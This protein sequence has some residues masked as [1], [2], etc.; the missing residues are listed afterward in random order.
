MFIAEKMCN[1]KYSRMFIVW[2]EIMSFNFSQCIQ[3][4]TIDRMQ[5]NGKFPALMRLVGLF[6]LHL[7]LLLSLWVLG[8]NWHLLHCILIFLVG[9]WQGCCWNTGVSTVL[10]Q[11]DGYAFSVFHVE[12]K[13]MHTIHHCFHRYE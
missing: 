12:W 8:F 2:F 10:L 4:C 3:I 6:W 11:L 7:N 5:K 1:F 9:S 13:Q